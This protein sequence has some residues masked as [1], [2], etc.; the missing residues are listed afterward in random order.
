VPLGASI[1]ELVAGG[2]GGAWVGINPELVDQPPVVTR[3]GP[4]GSQKTVTAG[5]YRVFSGTL[6]ADG[7]AWFNT[8]NEVL[9]VDAAGGT[10]T[11]AADLI[12]EQL[13]AGPDGTLWA[14]DD[15]E[16][17]RFPPV[18]APTRTPLRVPGCTQLH[19]SALTRA[20]DGAMWFM[21]VLCGLVRLAP[22]GRTTVVKLGDRATD[23]AA[24]AAGGVWFASDFDWR[25]GHVDV[26]G[27]VQM[28]AT[29]RRWHSVAVAP[30]GNAWFA[31]GR[32]QLM[33]ATPSGA[34]GFV[35]APIPADLIEFDPAGGQW[36]ASPARL[37]HNAP[38]APC[39]DTPP[40]LDVTPMGHVNHKGYGTVSLA[41]L[42]RARGFRIRVR[43]PVTIESSLVVPEEEDPFTG[44]A[45]IVEDPHGRTLRVPISARRLR[46]FARRRHVD[47]DLLIDARDSEGNAV[48]Y[49]V[50]L[51]VTP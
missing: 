12:T 34:L 50:Q 31:G 36:L 29:R 46:Q 24:D 25:A 45:T 51:R 10:S 37:V 26:N 3:V 35:P 18:G 17:I 22:D 38:A 49:E 16:L 8:G 42:R 33:R 44:L 39:D 14:V 47:L 32:C 19:T 28:L 41:A 20:S 48:G 23:L 27:K 30:D 15:D 1:D 40:R 7:N 5:R 2:D 11:V 43:E 4:D 13:A 21:D 9:R 6:G